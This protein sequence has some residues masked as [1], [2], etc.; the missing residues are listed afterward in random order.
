MK[1]KEAAALYND[2][3]KAVSKSGF[4][5]FLRELYNLPCQIRCNHDSHGSQYEDPRPSV[6]A[7]L[8]EWADAIDA[9]GVKDDE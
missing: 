6:V 8:R 4:G 1:A 9:I 5:E 3:A 2:V 7:F